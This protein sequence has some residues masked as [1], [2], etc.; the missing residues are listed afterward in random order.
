MARG[1]AIRTRTRG[2]TQSW[3]CPASWPESIWWQESQVENLHGLLNDIKQVY[4]VD[5]NRVYLL[6]MSDGATGAYYHAFKATTPWAAFLPFHGTL[7]CS[8]TPLPT[9]TARCMSPTF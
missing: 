6:G 8:R 7:A 3:C 9:P 4:N 5:E 1:G 2:Q